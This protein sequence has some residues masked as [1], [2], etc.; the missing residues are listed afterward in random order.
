MEQEF[1]VKEPNGPPAKTQIRFA[2]Q[3]GIVIPEG[4]TRGELDELI[5]AA[6]ANSKPPEA[7]QN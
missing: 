6:L 5:D 3:L 2:R 7:Q 1:H 4:V